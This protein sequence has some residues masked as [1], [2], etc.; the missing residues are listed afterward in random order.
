MAR[1][2]LCLET[3]E[4]LFVATQSIVIGKPKEIEARNSGLHLFIIGESAYSVNRFVLV[5][6]KDIFL[7]HILILI[8]TNL[9]IDTHN[10]LFCKFEHSGRAWEN[11]PRNH[12][13][14]NIELCSLQQISNDS[15]AANFI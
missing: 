4:T 15:T 9:F 10:Y 1:S 14:R 2:P 3:L 13:M 6:A 11:E 7:H 8:N 5:L 12:V